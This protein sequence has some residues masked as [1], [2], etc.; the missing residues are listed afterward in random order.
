MIDR[1]HQKSLYQFVGNFH[2]YLH[3]KDQL[4]HSLFFKILQRK[5]KLVI[6]GNLGMP[7]HRHLKSINLREPSILICIQKINFILYVF[8]EITER[9]CKLTLGSLGMPGYAHSKWYC[10]LVE[11]F[12]AYC[13]Q[14]VNF[15]NHIFLEILQRYENFL[16]WE[17]WA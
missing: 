11:N 3:A 16:F 10:Q 4:H 17:L 12:R 8:L 9:Y 7:G 6:L 13:R 15:I 2:A 5:S 14:K 1:P